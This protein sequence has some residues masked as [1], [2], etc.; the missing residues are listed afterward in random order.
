[1]WYC[2]VAALSSMLYQSDKS[3][4]SDVIANHTR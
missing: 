2:S 1:M 4:L 3:D